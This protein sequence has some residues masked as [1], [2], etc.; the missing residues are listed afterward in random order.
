MNSLPWGSP[1]PPS[2]PQSVYYSFLR[3]GDRIIQV[4]WLSIKCLSS[5]LPWYYATTPLLLSNYPTMT[6]SQCVQWVFKK[7]CR[8][9]PPTHP[10]SF[11]VTCFLTYRLKLALNGESQ[12]QVIWW[13]LSDLFPPAE[14][15]SQIPETPCLV[16]QHCIG[17]TMANIGPT[18]HVVAHPANNSSVHFLC[19]RSDLCQDCFTTFTFQ[20]IVATHGWAHWLLFNCLIVGGRGCEDWEGF[21]GFF[22]FKGKNNF[23]Q[24]LIFWSGVQVIWLSRVW[25]TFKSGR[26]ELG[27]VFGDG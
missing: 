21:V 18:M 2:A 27:V 14:R 15:S 26:G 20:I 9:L 24:N 25:N 11:K 3:G 5:P 13:L 7:N 10:F 22:L 23:A 17:P 6:K 8:P 1:R 12:R 16:R 4:W 19:S